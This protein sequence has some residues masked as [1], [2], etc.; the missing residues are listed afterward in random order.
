ME[1]PNEEREVHR[2]RKIPQKK[3]A[4]LDIGGMMERLDASKQMFWKKHE[5][6]LIHRTD[7]QKNIPQPAQSKHTDPSQTKEQSGPREEVTEL[8]TKVPWN[9]VPT[10][11]TSVVNMDCAWGRNGEIQNYWYKTQLLPQRK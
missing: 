7:K 5:C 10:P 2:K 8:L 1:S 3:D 4:G 6:A 11:V 9:L